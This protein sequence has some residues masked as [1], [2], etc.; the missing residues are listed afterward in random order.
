[1]ENLT[2]AEMER[3]LD[4]F[5]R[6]VYVFISP[7]MPLSS[8]DRDGNI[9]DCFWLVDYQG[10]LLILTHY[11]HAAA[12]DDSLRKQHYRVIW[13]LPPFK[14]APLTIYEDT[15]N[16][17]KLPWSPPATRFKIWRPWS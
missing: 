9:M 16:D 5:L 6:K 2:F 12:I 15:E 14:P 1:M 8:A 7:L 13:G 11:A 17:K 4:D 3:M 10:D